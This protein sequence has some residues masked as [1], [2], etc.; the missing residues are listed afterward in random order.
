MII[1]LKLL[2]LSILLSS[3]L[4]SSP[5]SSLFSYYQPVR[6]FLDP[7]TGVEGDELDGGL[8]GSGTAALPPEGDFL[9]ELDDDGEE[10]V[11]YFNPEM[12]EVYRIIS[13][14]TPSVSHA[15]AR[16]PADIVKHSTTSSSASSSAYLDESPDAEDGVQYL[17][18]WRGL[19]YAESTWEK[20][21]DLKVRGLL[22]V[23]ESECVGQ[24][25][26]VCGRE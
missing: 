9:E 7:R 24:R 15:T 1:I 2:T 20:Y 6:Q 16:S 23:V 26:S 19:S 11:E 21:E 18:K 3:L 13:C 12:A 14:D 10:E 17:V 22:S 25:V 4:S 8:D 5:Y